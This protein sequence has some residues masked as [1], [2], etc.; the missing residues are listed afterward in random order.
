MCS[1]KGRLPNRMAMRGVSGGL[2]LEVK[3]RKDVNAKQ[4]EVRRVYS[5]RINQAGGLPRVVSF[6]SHGV[7]SKLGMSVNRGVNYFKYLLTRCL[8]WFVDWK[9]PILQ[10]GPPPNLKPPGSKPLRGKPI[11]AFASPRPNSARGRAL[12]ALVGGSRTSLPGEV[13]PR[14]VELRSGVGF[15][16]KV[17]C[18][19]VKG[20]IPPC[21]LI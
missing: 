16:G 5:T 4:Q 7:P 17:I 19:F 10:T 14:S 13:C 15:G 6:N 2:G 18:H 1:R 11:N 12:K 21:K 3:L 9:P 8:D 20:D